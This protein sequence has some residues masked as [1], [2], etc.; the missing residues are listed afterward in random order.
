[1]ESW[2]LLQSGVLVGYE[3]RRHAYR[4]YH[5]ESG[6]IFVSAQVQF[7]ETTFP[8]EGTE[9]VKIAH[10]LPPVL[11][12]VY[13]DIHL[14]NQPPTIVSMITPPLVLGD[15]APFAPLLAIPEN[16]DNHEDLTMGGASS[17]ETNLG[18][19]LSDDN[20]SSPSPETD[21]SDEDYIPSEG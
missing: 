9:E 13:L 20:W 17:D 14:L 8:L 3:S 4:I 10:D 6:K 21:P 7:D 18:T 5:P 15:M 12:M 1:M 19:D 16:N 11:P 2:L